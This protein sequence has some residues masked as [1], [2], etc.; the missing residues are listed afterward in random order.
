VTAATAT[1]AV[2][3]PARDELVRDAVDHLYHAAKGLRRPLTV[4]QIHVIEGHI[5]AAVLALLTPPCRP[6]E[7]Q[8]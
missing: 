8:P 3:V 2:E 1:A 5:T 6:E 7:I 4:A